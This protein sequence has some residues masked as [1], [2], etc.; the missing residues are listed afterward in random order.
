MSRNYTSSKSKHP[1]LGLH[2]SRKR[3]L[4]SPLPFKGAKVPSRNG[5]RFSEN[6]E[7]EIDGSGDDLSSSPSS[8]SSFTLTTVDMSKRKR[9]MSKSPKHSHFSSVSKGVL[10]TGLVTAWDQPT[11]HRPTSGATGLSRGPKAHNRTSSAGS[12]E[13]SGIMSSLETIN[14]Q[15]GEL[16]C[17]LGPQPL[18]SGAMSLALPYSRY[19]PSPVSQ[20]VVG[21]LGTSLHQPSTSLGSGK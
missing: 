13:K 5:Q 14:G 1:K 16:L 9:A 11:I 21:D 8:S 10:S 15:L 17:R 18:T 7:S 4:T 2:S 20:L 12:D 19:T 6:L 3:N